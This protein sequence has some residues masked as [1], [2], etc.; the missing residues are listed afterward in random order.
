MNTNMKS[1]LYIL[2]HIL[3]AIVLVASLSLTTYPVWFIILLIIITIPGQIHMWNSGLRSAQFAYER[4]LKH[5]ENPIEHWESKLKFA[6]NG[7]ESELKKQTWA[8]QNSKPEDE[9]RKKEEYLN[10]WW[11][12][13][14]VSIYEDE[15]RKDEEHLQYLL[16]RKNYCEE[17]LI[18]CQ[19]EDGKRKNKEDLE[20]L[21]EEINYYERGFFRGFL[22]MKKYGLVFLTWISITCVIS[23]FFHLIHMID[24]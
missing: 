20:C 18:E 15:K 21:L 14:K 8:K 22:N 7:Y 3:V 23:W 2:R 24:N 9:K 6:Q 13:K 10:G 12:M 11:W 17:R 19:T 5:Q 1:N 4:E 16:E